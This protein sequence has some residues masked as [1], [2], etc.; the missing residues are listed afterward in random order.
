[1]FSGQEAQSGLLHSVVVTTGAKPGTYQAKLVSRSTGIM[2]QV[3]LLAK[4]TREVNNAGIHPW[5]LNGDRKS[6]IVL[7]NHSMTDAPVGIFISSG[8]TTVWTSEIVLSPSETREVSINQLQSEQIPDDHGMRIPATAKEGVADWRTPDSGQLTGRLMVTSHDMA[9]ARNFSCGTYYG[10]CYLNFTTFSNY[11]AAGG[12]GQLYEASADYCNYNANAINKCVN[13]GSDERNRSLLLERWHHKHRRAKIIITTN[14]PRADVTWRF[15]GRRIRKC[16]SP[17]WILYIYRRRQSAGW[18]S[19]A[20]ILS[21]GIY[22]WREHW[23]KSHLLV[24]YRSEQQQLGNRRRS[25]GQL[26]A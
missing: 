25:V 15:P 21:P 7:F 12:D 26:S 23:G 3:E 5:S 9:M 6:H 19:F 22:S 16:T 18:L 4:E 13:G 11:I 2:Y 17:S 14:R 8:T 10:V 1:V 24:Y 20:L